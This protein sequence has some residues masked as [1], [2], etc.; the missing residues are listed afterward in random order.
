MP[1]LPPVGPAQRQLEDFL[2][3]D[4]PVIR[5][6]AVTPQVV[7]ELVDVVEPDRLLNR[8]RFASSS[9]PRGARCLIKCR[10]GSN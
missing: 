7:T 4:R 2:L 8:L 9:P 3:R 5:E 6:S 1:H 10:I